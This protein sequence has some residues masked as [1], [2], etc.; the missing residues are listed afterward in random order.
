MGAIWRHSFRQDLFRL[1]KAR[2]V[3]VTSKAGKRSESNVETAVVRSI[4]DIPEAQWTALGGVG[5]SGW[6]W[7]KTVEESAIADLAPRHLIIL[8]G[9]EIVGSAPCY[10]RWTPKAGQPEGVDKL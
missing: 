5:Y 1:F 3:I 4:L 2:L 6:R 7:L 9:G 10:R 8:S